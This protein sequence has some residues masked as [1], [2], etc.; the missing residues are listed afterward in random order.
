MPTA[1]SD[2]VGHSRGVKPT[3]EYSQAEL[4]LF[5]LYREDRAAYRPRKCQPGCGMCWVEHGPPAIA[6]VGECQGCGGRPR[7]VR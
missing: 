1:R 5:A 4:N 2:I 3:R 6:K 7:E